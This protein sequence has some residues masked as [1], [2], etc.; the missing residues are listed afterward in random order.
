MTTAV[1]RPG[2]AGGAVQPCPKSAA[3]GP[4]APGP[5]Q[6]L[7]MSAPAEV[8]AFADDMAKLQQDW[9]SLSGRARLDRLQAMVDARAASAGFPAPD[10]TTP[11]EL[12]RQNGELNFK[13]WEI[14]IN[15]SLV[16]S[17]RLSA[18]QTAELGDTLYH[19]TRHAE[20]WSLIAKRQA[21]E[22]LA[23]DQIR[24]GLYVPDNVATDAVKRPLARSDSRRPCADA[25]YKSI[26]GA[27]RVARN[28]TIDNLQKH[29][30]AYALA[31]Q[32]YE[33]AVAEEKRLMSE[34]SRQLQSYTA[35]KERKPPPTEAEL[36]TLAKQR[37]DSAAKLRTAQLRSAECRGRADAARQ[38]YRKTYDDY[39][40]LPEEVDAW[41]AG[42][43]SST[44]IMARLSEGGH[45]VA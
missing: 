29:G 35:C 37:N 22:G 27:G 4:S 30:K 13:E 5:C 6:G 43:R 19:E 26:Y 11:E 38:T 24:Y 42:G 16:R 31:N 23:A 41:D 39:R 40:A 2:G 15:P 7:G 33:R 28:A 25:L 17:E 45:G 32:E 3:G 8:D 14:A 9:P 21:G 36:H 44:A 18:E 1:M 10:V 12:G 34:L 20:Q